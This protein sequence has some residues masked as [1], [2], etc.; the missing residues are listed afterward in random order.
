MAAKKRDFRHYGKVRHPARRAI[1][2]LGIRL[3]IFFITFVVVTSVF[4]NSFS[5]GSSAMEPTFSPGD[6][7]FTTPLIFGAVV[8]FSNLR[9][10]AIRTPRRG[11]LVVCNPPFSTSTSLQRL[12]DP[13]VGFFTLR[14][15]RTGEFRNSTWENNSFVKRVIGIPGDTVVMENF[16]AFVKPPGAADFLNERVINQKEYTITLSPLPDDWREEFPFSGGMSAVILGDDEYFVLGDN[17][18]ESHD[19]RFF[20]PVPEKNIIQKVMFRFW[21]VRRAGVP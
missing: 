16:V 7:I 4:I 6:R 9:F 13:F 1:R 2:K 5:I 20:G 19:S 17:R 3:V 12:I 21:P 18:T 10:P 8:P 14:K 11:D 15:V